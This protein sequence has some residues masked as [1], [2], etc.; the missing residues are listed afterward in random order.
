KRDW[1]SDVCSSDLSSLS[2]LMVFEFGVASVMVTA[3]HTLDDRG[4]PHA[5]TDAQGYK[6]TLR[7][8]PLQLVHHGAENHRT[9]RTERMPHRDRSTVDVDLF[10]RN[11]QIGHPLQHDGGEC[12]V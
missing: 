1:S 3:S 5:A 2:H 12:L 8:T 9:G 10:F 4:Q 11:I 6:G 7:L